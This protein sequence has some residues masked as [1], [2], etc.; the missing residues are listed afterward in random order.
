[1]AKFKFLIWLAYWY[2]QSEIFYF[3][4]DIGN[5]RKN[6]KKHGVSTNEFESV[7][8]LKMAVPLGIQMSP[9]VKEERFCIVGPTNKG[10]MLSIVFVMRDGKVRPISCRPASQKERGLYEEIS[11]AIKDL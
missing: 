3:E 6:N 7:F 10:R 11:K 4:W 5:Q 9:I 8:E 2:Q 1:M